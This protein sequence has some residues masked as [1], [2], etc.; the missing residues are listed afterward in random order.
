VRNAYYGLS[1][2]ATQLVDVSLSVNQSQAAT[3]VVASQRGTMK[4]HSKG[5]DQIVANLRKHA[6][7]AHEREAYAL[8]DE[9]TETILPDVK[10][11]TTVKTGALRDIRP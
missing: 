7:K 9:L 4:V 8:V 6:A 1:Q 11:R 3:A 5:M 2:Q 10:A